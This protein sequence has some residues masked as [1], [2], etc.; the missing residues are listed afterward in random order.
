MTL[1]G[2]ESLEVVWKHQEL[3]CLEIPECEK[4]RKD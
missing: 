2:L 4:M 1:A 3:A